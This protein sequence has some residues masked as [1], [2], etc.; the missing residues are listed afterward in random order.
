MGPEITSLIHSGAR[1]YLL[2]NGT[3]LCL[4]QLDG[5]LYRKIGNEKI[6]ILHTHN[7][8]EIEEQ[9]HPLLVHANNK[10]IH[11]E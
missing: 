2:R 8:T 10:I 7:Y 5:C 11:T 3:H 4:I 6:V 1:L 9:F